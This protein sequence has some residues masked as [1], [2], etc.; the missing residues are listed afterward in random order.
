VNYKDFSGCLK[1]C[2]ILFLHLGATLVSTGVAK[3]M[4]AYRVFSN[5]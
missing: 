5:S 2:T 1:L 4:W 3:Q